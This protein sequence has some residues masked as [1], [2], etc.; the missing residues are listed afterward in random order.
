MVN[1][2]VIENALLCVHS[3]GSRIVNSYHSFVDKQ[4]SSFTS[5]NK[6]NIGWTAVCGA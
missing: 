6:G 4:K 2:S 3:Q 1:N 5:N